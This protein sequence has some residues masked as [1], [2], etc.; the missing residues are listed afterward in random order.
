MNNKKLLSQVAVTAAILILPTVGHVQ[1][2]AVPVDPKTTVTATMDGGTAKTGNTW[3][4]KGVNAA[5]PTSGITV[6]QIVSGQTDPLSSYLFQ[7]ASGNNALMLDSGKTSGSLLFSRPL[8]LTGL[9]LSGASGNGRGTNTLTLNFSDGTKDTLSPL[10]F[11]DW[12][13]VEPRVQT[14]GGRIDAGANVFNNVGDANPRILAINATLSAADQAKLITS[15]DFTWT[16]S[17]ANTHT[18]IFGVSGDFTGLGHFS[19]IPLEAGSFNQDVIVGLQE[20][21]EPGTLALLGL[22]AAGLLAFARRRTS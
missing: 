5:A 10:T 22:G 21:P 6:G 17:G 12:F 8:S 18:A 20:V 3:Y 4:E 9:S 16:G 11:G 14:A 13:G 19:A 7:P 2:A 15:I 1:G